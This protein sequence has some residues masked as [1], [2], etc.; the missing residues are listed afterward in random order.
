MS[1]SLFS[2][3]GNSAGKCRYKLNYSNIKRVVGAGTIEETC[4]T[5]LV[6]K[7]RLPRRKT[8]G[9]STNEELLAVIQVTN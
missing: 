9:K 4:M 7:R 8:T 3:D 1:H 6:Y 5:F 2:V